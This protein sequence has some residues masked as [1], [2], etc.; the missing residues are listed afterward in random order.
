MKDFAVTELVVCRQTRGARKLKIGRKRS[1]IVQ[2]VLILLS[3]T[4]FDIRLYC[5]FRNLDSRGLILFPHRNTK[6]P[7]CARALHYVLKIG[8]RAKNIHFFRDVL[9]MKVKQ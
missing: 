5:V 9:G 6:M 2:F 3:S 4:D 8:D 1:S 7:A